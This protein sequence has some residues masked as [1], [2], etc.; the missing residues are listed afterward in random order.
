MAQLRL[1]FV[2]KLVNIIELKLFMAYVVHIYSLRSL[3]PSP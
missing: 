2:E 3:T 1:C